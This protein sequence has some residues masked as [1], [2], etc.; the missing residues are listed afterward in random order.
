MS[1][2]LHVRVK[3]WPDVSSFLH[4]FWGWTKTHIFVQHVIHP[5]N[6]LLGPG[7][8]KNHFKDINVLFYL[9]SP[10][11]LFACLRTECACKSI[12]G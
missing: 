3:D 10:N 2:P 5:L 1:L 4:R 8:F 11:V 12:A 9:E 6:C 7:V